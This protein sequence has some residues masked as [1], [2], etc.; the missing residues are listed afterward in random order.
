MNVE[1]VT[2][3]NFIIIVVLGLIQS[4][5]LFY[6]V[7]P[8]FYV[9]GDNE[10]YNQAYKVISTL[11]II[12]GYLVFHKVGGSGTEPISYFFMFISSKWLTY[13]QYFYF[14]NIIFLTVFGMTLQKYCIFMLF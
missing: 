11:G 14:S 3:I 7:Y 8:D 12:E 1:K 9:N 4:F 13:Q 10:F 2:L 5:F 6:L